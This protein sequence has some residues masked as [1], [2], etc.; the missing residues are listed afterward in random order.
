MVVADG[1]QK[2][3]RSVHARPR[4]RTNGDKLAVALRVFWGLADASVVVVDEGSCSLGLLPVSHEWRFAFTWRD[5]CRVQHRCYQSH[6]LSRT[7][8]IF[9]LING[10]QRWST[11]VNGCDGFLHSHL[12]QVTAGL[13][14]CSLLPA[15]R[16]TTTRAFAAHRA[17]TP[18]DLTPAYAT[19]PIS[20]ANPCAARHADH[21]YITKRNTSFLLINH[22]SVL[23]TIT[24]TN[25]DPR[26]L[27]VGC[28]SCG[29][30]SCVTT[31][32]IRF[33]LDA[34]TA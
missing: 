8:Y 1:S 22:L 3:W 14:P 28:P 26:V 16:T 15:P 10:G 6:D 25:L 19:H 24:S 29:A 31:D 7:L 34:F 17:N 4:L 9:T 27:G 21:N 2:T 5:W 30:L 13:A 12:L 33:D 23:F 11:M 18:L 32:R 20:N